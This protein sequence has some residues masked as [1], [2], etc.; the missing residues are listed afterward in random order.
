MTVNG[1][2]RTRT[3]FP[4][5]D[6]PSGKRFATTV[7]PRTQTF[8][9]DATSASVKNEPEARCHQLLFQ[10]GLASV[11]Q[12]PAKR[13]Q[14]G[15]VSR[16]QDHCLQELLAHHRSRDVADRRRTACVDDRADD[17]AHDNKR[18]QHIQRTTQPSVR[19]TRREG[20]TPAVRFGDPLFEHTHPA[21]SEPESFEFP[22][23]ARRGAIAPRRRPA[24][25]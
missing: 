19:W 16:A 5:R 6:W 14:R 20:R 9:E 24:S 12:P 23:N 13:P 8:A 4:R 18:S 3:V 15:R 7:W 1:T 17:E 10:P 25:L 22:A 11:R 2:L 21:L